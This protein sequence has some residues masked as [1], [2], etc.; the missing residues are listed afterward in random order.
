[1]D[2]TLCG[3]LLYLF[4][5]FHIWLHILA[6]IH[7]LDIDMYNCIC[8]I[9]E[10]CYDGWSR[11]NRRRSRWWE[12]VKLMWVACLCVWVMGHPICLIWWPLNGLHTCLIYFPS[13]D[14]SSYSI[15]LL[16]INEQVTANPMASVSATCTLYSYM[17][18]I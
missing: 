6:N 7:T 18:L 10:T 3:A 4:H 5:K 12:F 2:G 15:I 17:S 11:R 16:K 13:S 8:R 9:W 1:M 14:L